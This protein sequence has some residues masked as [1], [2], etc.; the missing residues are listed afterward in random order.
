LSAFDSRNELIYHLDHCM[1]M[2]SKS[3]FERICA[4]LATDKDSIIRHNPIGTDNEVLLWMLLSCLNSYLSLNE[5]EI[6][7]FKG[8]PDEST[9][10]EAILF[11]LK[12][13]TQDDFDPGPIIDNLVK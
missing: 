8:V 1:T 13:R 2:I 3:E 10:R 12:K 9:Y 5:N 4:G 6:P 11:V 7:C